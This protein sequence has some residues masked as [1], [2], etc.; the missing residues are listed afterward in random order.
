MSIS[1]S[2]EV[3]WELGVGSWELGV[4]SWEVVGS[5]RWSPSLEWSCT[6]FL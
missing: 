2:S 6:I 4:G 1:E 3:S 5:A